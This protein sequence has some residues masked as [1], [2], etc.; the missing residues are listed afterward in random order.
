MDKVCEAK[1]YLKNRIAYWKHATET[2]LYNDLTTDV[3]GT[4]LKMLTESCGCVTC[5]KTKAAAD[6]NSR[7]LQSV[8]GLG[9]RTVY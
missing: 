6:P 8:T 9:A 7:F 1:A 2:G 3:K 5:V 4:T